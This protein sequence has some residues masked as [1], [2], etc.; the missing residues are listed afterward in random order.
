[1][2]APEISS[3]VFAGEHF[4]ENMCALRPGTAKQT[5]GK[6]N[7][8]EAETFTDRRLKDRKTEK[9]ERQKDRKKETD[10]QKDGQTEK[11]RD[12]KTA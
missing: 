5:S 7:N 11:S 6:Q 3:L 4:M 8:R 1:M 9:T 12:R 10:R 2:R